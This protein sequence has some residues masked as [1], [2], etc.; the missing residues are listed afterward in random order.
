MKAG[1]IGTGN[2]QAV[3]T[4][5]ARNDTA[6]LSTQNAE[7]AAWLENEFPGRNGRKSGCCRQ[8]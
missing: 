2:W 4:G 1:L 3:A 6:L 5:M 7:N 8:Q